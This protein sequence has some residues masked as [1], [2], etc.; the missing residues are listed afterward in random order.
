MDKT[1]ERRDLHQEIT[2]KIVSAIEAGAGQWQL[3]WIGQTGGMPVNAT[4]GAKYHGVNIIS[5]WMAGTTQGYPTQEWASYKQWAAKGAQVRGGERGSLIVYYEALKRE[6]TDDATGET[7]EERIP[8]LK[9]SHVFN[10]AQADGYQAETVER[11]SLA[12]RTG[13]AEAFVAAT[14]ATVQYGLGRAFYAPSRDVIGMPSWDAFINTATATATENAYGTLLHELT[15]WTGHQTRC[16]RDF[17]KRFGSE[18]YAAEELVAELGA[19][20]LCSEIGI[21]PEPRSDHAQYLAHWLTIL[22]GDKKA[23][24]TAAS[25]ASAAVDFLQGLQPQQHAAMAA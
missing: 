10:A 21:T 11:P 12:Q 24:F 19:A 1:N 20:F 17:A 6:T 22:K 15:H 7:V 18:A 13:S 16:A 9:Y 14:G 8:F 23:I 2:N 25:K 3:P 5:L 4:T